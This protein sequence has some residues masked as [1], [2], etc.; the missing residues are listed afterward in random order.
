MTLLTP[1]VRAYVGQTAE[2][3][4]A[5]PLGRASIRYFAMALRDPNPL[6]ID[7][8][9]G[10]ENGWP[11]VVA[12]PTLVCETCQ[13]ARGPVGPDDDGYFGHV[14]RLPFPRP[15][16]M[17]RGGNEY[18]FEVPATPDTVLHVRWELVSLDERSSLVVARARGSYHDQANH[19][20]A[21][22]DETLLFRPHGRGNHNELTQDRKSE[23]T[24]NRYESAT[25]ATGRAAAGSS[26]RPK[27]HALP[28][29]V[30]A[31]TLVD[32]VAYAAAT[33]DWHPLHYDPDYAISVGLPGPVVDG[34]MW[35]ALIARQV[36]DWAGPAT[37]LRHLAVR[38]HG[39]VTA[40]ETVILRAWADGGDLTHEV[41]AGHRLVATGSSALASS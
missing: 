15:C 7:D 34:Q 40:G 35:G 32:L 29:T 1:E 27:G 19:L 30:R 36:L 37:R 13:Y 24:T 38:Y 41:L 11:G 17:L 10:R 9:F 22:N 6:W 28:E 18:T 26:L 25:L 33:W 16:D 2:Y 12:P 23:S 4:A 39:F 21:T 5:E 3:V 20:L 31:M 8:D 14:W